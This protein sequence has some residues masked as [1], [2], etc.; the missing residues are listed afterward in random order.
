MYYFRYGSSFSIRRYFVLSSLP[1]T[2]LQHILQV[3]VCAVTSFKILFVISCSIVD[4]LVVFFAD[5]IERVQLTTVVISLKTPKINFMSLFQK[6]FYGKRHI[7][8]KIGVISWRVIYLFIPCLKLSWSYI[9]A[10]MYL[11][12]SSGKL[13]PASLDA[14][15][16]RQDSL[17]SLK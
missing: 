16:V 4:T 14:T 11:S 8:S 1:F 10:A 3:W 6:I 2:I 7:K 9:F 17:Q 12:C 5:L 13:C 15:C